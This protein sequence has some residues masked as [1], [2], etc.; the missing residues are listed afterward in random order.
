MN[1][2]IFMLGD[3]PVRIIDA[4]IGFSALV[5]ILLVVIAVVIAKSGRRGAELAKDLFSHDCR[6]R[7]FR[8]LRPGRLCRLKTA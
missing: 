2:I 3:W 5:L 1:E 6:I 8:G 7:V 4:L